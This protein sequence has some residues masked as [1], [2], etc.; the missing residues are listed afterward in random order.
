ME[1]VEARSYLSLFGNPACGDLIG[2]NRIEKDKVCV[3]P[4]LVWGREKGA[5]VV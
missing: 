1:V 5:G 3:L 2:S 4:G